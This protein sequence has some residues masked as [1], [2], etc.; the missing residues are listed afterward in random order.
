MESGMVSDVVVVVVDGVQYDCHNLSGR[1]VG[2][3]THVQNFVVD[4]HHDFHPRWKYR[5]NL[6][7]ACDGPLGA[8]PKINRV[9]L[10]GASP[11]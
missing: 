9:R 11:G 2:C 6:H 3:Y 4:F 7:L 5:H 8:V 1:H 10:Y